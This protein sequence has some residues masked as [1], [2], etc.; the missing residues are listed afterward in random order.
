M[1]ELKYKTIKSITVYGDY[2]DQIKFETDD[3]DIIYDAVGDCCSAS[4]F[5]DIWNAQNIIG[6]KVV[7][8]EELQLEDGDAPYRPSREEYDSI[9]GFRLWNEDDGV[10]VIIFRNSSNGYYGGECELGDKITSENKKF[11]HKITEENWSA[12]M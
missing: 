4:Y 12:P 8:V 2:Q 3:G 7:R 9:Y 6:K 1:K 5:S 10:C 11:E